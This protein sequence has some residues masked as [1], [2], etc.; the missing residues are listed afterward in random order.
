MTFE[1]L[2]QLI[3][4]E[5]ARDVSDETVQAWCELGR[6]R[7][8]GAQGKW[9]WMSLLKQTTISAVNGTSDYTSPFQSG[10]PSIKKLLTIER[11]GEQYAP[12]TLYNPEAFAGTQ[13][14]EPF[15]GISI[16]AVP[17][18]GQIKIRIK[19][20]PQANET[21]DCWYIRQADPE[22]LGFV[23]EENHDVFYWAALCF[24]YSKT[25]LPGPGQEGGFDRAEAMFQKSLNAAILNDYI[26]ASEVRLLAPPA[27]M[28]QVM[29]NF[30]TIRNSR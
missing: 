3:K 23:Q 14:V 6:M 5:A 27:I 30:E 4:V 25:P 1:N 9:A 16:I 10:D 8:L 2:V 22:D 29:N 18:P 24:A 20:T 26:A 15:E 28:Q 17:S 13:F 11:Q 21:L 7:V 19:T 12:I